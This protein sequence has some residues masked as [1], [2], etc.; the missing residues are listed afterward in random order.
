MS[1]Q[2]SFQSIIIPF[3]CCF[4]DFLAEKSIT[5]HGISVKIRSLWGITDL[6]CS[7]DQNLCLLDLFFYCIPEKRHPLPFFQFFQRLAAIDFHTFFQPFLRK[8]LAHGRIIKFQHH[9]PD[10]IIVFACG[11]TLYKTYKLLICLRIGFLQKIFHYIFFQKFQFSFFCNPVSRIQTDHMKIIPDDPGT[12]TVN[13]CDLCIVDQRHLS[14]KMFIVRFIV[15][16]LFYGS[17]DPFFHFSGSSSGKGHDQQSVN[18]HRSVRV[19]DLAQN[20]LYQNGSLTGTGGCTDQN[21][22]VP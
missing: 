17:G 9:I 12:E 15:Q 7:V 11:I 3:F 4:P 10:I 16:C 5:F 2:H 14:L 19:H 21:I 18:I 1:I 20:P 6:Q 22:P 8:R 13:G